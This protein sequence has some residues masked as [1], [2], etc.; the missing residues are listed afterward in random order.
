MRRGVAVAADDQHPRQGQPLFWT[1]DVHYA[2]ARVLQAEQPEAV[3]Q[4][5]V[6]QRTHHPRDLG[7]GDVLGA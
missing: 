6:V 2:L 5:I 4:G 7:I 3:T 1:D